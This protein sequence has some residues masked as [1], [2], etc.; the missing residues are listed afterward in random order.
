MYRTAAI[1]AALKT[2]SVKDSNLSLFLM[3]SIENTF[4]TSIIEIVSKIDLTIFLS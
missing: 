3:L 1:L 4:Y 2:F